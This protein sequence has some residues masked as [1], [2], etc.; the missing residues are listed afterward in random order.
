MLERLSTAGFDIA[1][2]SHAE[3]IL[4]ADFS[5]LAKELEAVL[6]DVRVPIEETIGGGGGEALVT[7]RMRR[8]LV[9]A[10]W[11]KSVFTVQKRITFTA[12]KQDVEIP[13]Q[14]QSHEIDHV[15]QF[16]N[17]KRIAMEIEWNNKDPFFDRDLENFKRLHADSAISAGI[18]ITRGRSLHDA[19]LPMVRRFLEQQAVD[20][21]GTLA[22][23]RIT[24]TPRQAEAIRKRT[25]RKDNPVPF[26]DALADQFVSDKFGKATTHWRKLE[27]RLQRGVG[28]PCPL[29]LI[30]LPAGIVTFD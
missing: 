20:D 19:M 28:N 16:A 26:R 12:G 14:S 22:R 23:F 11:R 27:D 5:E 8:A 10:G 13:S 24:P 25:Q 15:R 30:G 29:L 6:L 7:Q 18:I 3:A 17:G 1:F 4:G 2:T 21:L 9:E